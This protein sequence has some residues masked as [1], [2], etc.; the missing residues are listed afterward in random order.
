MSYFDKRK[1]LLKYNIPKMLKLVQQET[2]EAHMQ[3]HWLC[4]DD[5]NHENSKIT[6]YWKNQ[7]CKY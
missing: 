5:F 3:E 7:K 4:L 1:N 6:L 2:T